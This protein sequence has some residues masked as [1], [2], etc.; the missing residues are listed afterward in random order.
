MKTTSLHSVDGYIAAFPPDVREQLE[1]LR[2]LIQKNAPKAEEVISYKM[3]AYKLDGMLVYFAG[4][5]K[6]IGFYPMPSAIAA[7]RKEIAGY[8]SAK[9][10][11]QF[12]V[13]KPLPVK[14][15][16]AMV[17]FRVQENLAKAKAKKKSDK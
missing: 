4:Y 17:K 11:V 16:T 2:A 1:K 14:L 3:P 9:G 7:F 5:E 6:H 10:S 8:K 12:P 15:I 13:D